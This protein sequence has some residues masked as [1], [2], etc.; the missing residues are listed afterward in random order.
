MITLGA[1]QVSEYTHRPS[2]IREKEE[3]KKKGK[4]EA[5]ANDDV[6]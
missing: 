2:I 5:M 3:M 1:V 4:N 6:I